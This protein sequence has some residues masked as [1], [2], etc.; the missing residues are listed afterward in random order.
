MFV[1]LSTS[2]SYWSSGARSQGEARHACQVV[3]SSETDTSRIVISHLA[4]LLYMNKVAVRIGTPL[5]ASVKE[6]STEDWL[7]VREMLHHSSF[8][9]I[10]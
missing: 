6:Y 1:D 4:M 9:S 10:E 5:L 7:T 2:S 8:A 3:V